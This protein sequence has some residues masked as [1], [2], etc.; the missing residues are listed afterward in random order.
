[1]LET[2]PAVRW[3]F[4]PLEALLARDPDGLTW[5]PVRNPADL[6][7]SYDLFLLLQDF[8]DD[9]LAAI[10]TAARAAGK[11]VLSP[12]SGKFLEISSVEA[13]EGK[14]DR[15]AWRA[16]PEGAAR[17]EDDASWDDYEPEPLT[18]FEDRYERGP[19][20]GHGIPAV[21]CNVC[22]DDFD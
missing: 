18:S 6:V 14:P 19:T 1:M 3:A 11:T 5:S 17:A 10:V 7:A 20:C 12:E 8:I 2:G 22:R 13:N 9:S 15:W 21:I 4:Y 16:I